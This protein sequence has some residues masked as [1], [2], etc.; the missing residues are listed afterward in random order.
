MSRRLARPVI[1]AL[2]ATVA[3]TTTLVGSA[4]AAPLSPTAD[5]VVV[6]IPLTLKQS[7]E[8]RALYG[9][10]TIRI[11]NSAP[12][13]VTVDTGSVGLRLL[14]GAWKTTPKG[15]SI[16]DRKISWVVDGQ[17]LGGRVGTAPFSISNIH[18]TTPI[19]FMW[20][21]EN[22]WTKDAVRQ[23]IQGVLGIGLSKQQLINPLT[24]LPGDVS[25]HWS[26]AFH[27]N[28]ARTGGTG[29]LVLGATTPSDAL[30]TIPLPTQ[31]VSP[32]GHL[33]W[34]DQAANVCWKIADVAECG[35]T[36]FDSMA[37]F[38]L[39]KGSAFAALPTTK[40]GLLEPGTS[41]QMG[42]PGAAFY[43]WN[44]NSGLRFGYNAAKVSGR[45]NTLV[46]TGSAL[47]SAFTVTY[48]AVRGSVALSN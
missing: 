42:A 4:A 21:N 19:N 2:V 40:L 32:N 44:F 25:R 45:G 30:A 20:M 8:T 5:N 17:R 35:A 11:G 36:Y 37:P 48:D 9:M 24:A 14:P 6:D 26:V 31:G 41:V 33:Y 22:S 39:I 18:A 47:Y 29:N 10:T 27:P 1:A 3:V 16:S 12:I 28:A 43:V 34:N 15:V 7:P 46:N 23:G 38:M 13:R